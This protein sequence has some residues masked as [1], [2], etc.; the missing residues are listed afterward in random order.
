MAMANHK[1]MIS[2]DEAR[3][4]LLEQ[5]N[6]DFHQ[7]LIRIEKRFE[8]IDARFDTLEKRMD[9]QFSKVDDRFS[10]L[11]NKVDARLNKVETRIEKLDSRI[12]SNFKWILGFMISGF[13]GVTGIMAHGFKWF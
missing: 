7:T 5:K 13:A 3:I 8:H 4:M 9:S 1:D 11:E 10:S 2:T 12:D 6:D